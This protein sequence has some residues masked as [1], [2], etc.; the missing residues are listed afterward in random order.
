MHRCRILYESI[1]ELD[2]RTDILSLSEIGNSDRNG[3][4]ESK[5]WGGGMEVIA[6]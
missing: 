4:V 3:R 1:E 2:V 5:T 6:Q